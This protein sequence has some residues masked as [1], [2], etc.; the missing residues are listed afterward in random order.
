MVGSAF[1]AA[2]NSFKL[3][4]TSGSV[5]GA[6]RA[7]RSIGVRTSVFAWTRAVAASNREMLEKS[8]MVNQCEPCELDKLNA[9][10]VVKIV[11]GYE[12]SLR[13]MRAI[14]TGAQL[15]LKRAWRYVADTKSGLI[16]FSTAKAQRRKDLG[17][18][19]IF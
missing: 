2:R 16:G 5:S 15:N 14:E 19:G 18:Q 11:E 3:A 9:R 12:V 7:S 1:S 13:L 6:S 17:G 8:R 4:S 10:G